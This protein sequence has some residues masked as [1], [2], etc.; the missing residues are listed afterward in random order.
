M[1]VRQGQMKSS[2]SRLFTLAASAKVK[3]P[4]S[5]PGLHL[6]LR[7]GER[8]RRGRLSLPPRGPVETGSPLRSDKERGIRAKASETPQKTGPV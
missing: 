6:R 7:R 3:H 5:A 2:L 1:V 8:L 4:P